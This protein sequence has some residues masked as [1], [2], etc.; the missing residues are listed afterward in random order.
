MIVVMLITFTIVYAV[1]KRKRVK[2]AAAHA[3]R[4]YQ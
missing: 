4:R 1:E 3:R 2:M